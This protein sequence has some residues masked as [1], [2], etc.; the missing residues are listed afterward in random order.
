[1][2][3]HASCANCT[4]NVLSP[5][6]SCWPLFAHYRIL[7]DSFCRSLFAYCCRRHELCSRVR[8]CLVCICLG[9]LQC[10]RVCSCG[11][12]VTCLCGTHV[13]AAS[14]KPYLWPQQICVCWLSCVLAA[15]VCCCLFFPDV[16]LPVI[17]GGLMC[18]DPKE[19]STRRGSVCGLSQSSKQSMELQ[20]I[21]NCRQ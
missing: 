16:C 8:G 2:A 14:I 7:F 4:H 3:G 15:G 18:M 21:V 1:M 9:L 5:P 19:A 13:S 17:L 20:S 12:L 10:C 11:V 6:G